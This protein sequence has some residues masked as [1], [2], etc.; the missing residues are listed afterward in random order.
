MADVTLGKTKITVNKNG[1]GAL[2]VQRVSVEEAGT[3]LK[4]AFNHGITFFD[5]ARAYS[6]SEEKLGLAFEGIR[7]KI[8][9]ATKTAA[10]TAEG[11][12][13]DLEE[14][15]RLLKTDYIDLYQFHNPA[16]CPKPGDGSGLYEAMLEARERGTV[17]HIGITNHRLHVAAEAVE[18]GLYE[19]LQFPFSY[20]ASEKEL[21]LVEACKA[22]DMGFIAMKALS[23]GLITNS[24]AAYAYLA[25]FD[26][27]LPIWGIQREHELDEFLSYIDNP[28]VMTEELEAVIE[29]DRKELLGE[30]CRGCGY[31]M[32]C[33]AEIEINTCAR[34]SLLIRRSP[35]AGH[36]TE[37]S[38]N[39]MMKIKDCLHC[40]QCSS[41][42]PYGL[43]TPALLERNLKDYEEILGGKA[44]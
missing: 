36:L 20:L 6:D 31:C 42:C 39:M 4:K 43:D 33:P 40:G 3:L 22:A 10:D 24:A 8:Y 34:M 32:P 30:F 16:V 19:T 9:I 14:S 17:R 2:P 1:F 41:K 29:H 21:E 38:Q 7:E 25:K 15:L 12:R 27:V 11:F 28:P 13:R 18:S 37:A 23:G 35:S 5:T 26:N 44:Y